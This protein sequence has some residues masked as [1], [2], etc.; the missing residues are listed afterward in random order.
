MGLALKKPQGVPGKSWPA[1]SLPLGQA[2]P[3]SPSFRAY[4]GYRLSLAC[5]LPLE[6]CSLGMSSYPMAG[7]QKLTLHRYDT[8]TISGILAMP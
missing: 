7:L 2:S 6:V 4:L 5:L 8:G 1:V 3:P